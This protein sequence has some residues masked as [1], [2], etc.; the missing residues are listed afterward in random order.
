EPMPA[1]V[2]LGPEFQ[3]FGLTA[4]AQ[5]N[6]G[7]CSLFAVTALAEFALARS[8]PENV[9]RLSEEYLI[10]AAHAASAPRADD[11]AMFYQTLHGLN[12]EGICISRLMPYARRPD[13]GRKP[14][15]EALADARTR[16]ER[17]KIHW[18]KRWD[19]NTGLQPVELTAIKQALVDCHAVACGLRW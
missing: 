5:G 19:A 14:S 3:K 7:D 4:R 1:A 10:W 16:S 6:R 17:W 15:E 18:I 13:A 8:A 9:H 2:D 11:Q 12:A